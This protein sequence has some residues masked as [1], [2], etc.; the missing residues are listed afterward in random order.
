MCGIAGFLDF[1]GIDKDKSKG[2][3]KS[4][5]NTLIHRGPD[6]EGYYLDQ[7]VALGHR[8]LSIIDLESG[9][10]PMVEL[11]KAVIVF[12]G[13]IYNFK[14]V[15]CELESLGYSF[16]TNSDTEVIL[17]SYLQWGVECLNRLNGMFA[18][19]IW[20]IEKKI[21]FL[22]RDRIGKK[23]LYYTNS[24]GKI[25]FGSEIKAL[26]TT[27]TT[28]KELDYE[29]LDCFF[30]YGY[31]PSPKTIFKDIKKLEPGHYLIFSKNGL[32]KKRYWT[33]EFEPQDR[34]SIEDAAD[35][36]LDIFKDAVKIRMI[37]DVPL[38]AFLSGGIDSPLVVSMMSELSSKKVLTNSIGFD[39]DK[40]NE[41]PIA[42]EIATI[43]N[44]NHKEYVVKPEIHNVLQKILYHLDEPIADSS[45]IPTYYVC[46]IAKQSCTVSL[47]GDG[48]DE[49][50]GG[51]TFRYLPHLYE[52]K[53]KKY[54][55]TTIR[56]T[57]FSLLG[58]IYPKSPKLPNVLRLK[59]IFQNLSVSDE[60]AFFKDLIWLPLEIR[61]NLYS[62][63][64][65]RNL[66]GFTPFECIYPLYKKVKHLDPVSRAQYCDLNFYLPE[67]VLVKVDRMSMAVSLEVRAPLLDYRIIEFGAKLP[68]NLKVS[69]KKG[70]LVLR[71]VL[72]RY[73]PQE[74]INRPKQGFS[75]PEAKW[76]VT[77]LRPLIEK[78]ICKQN[79][80]IQE[81]FDVN[82]LKSLWQ[83][84]IKNEENNSVF[85]WGLMIFSLWEDRFYL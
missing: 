80:L 43:L 65:K 8:R 9:N 20:D 64:F 22:A 15:R 39:V 49:S 32:T 41:L 50:F 18:F 36:F 67:D 66:H 12:N 24:N 2:L 83:K 30:S 23:P 60:M 75:I 79:S 46:K 26:T 73:I 4:M 25:L 70:K 38:G 52:C 17:K 6:E 5:V 14:Q 71:H 69:S 82:Y 63:N 81:L 1:R 53:L 74:I 35:E 16:S 19:A 42:R 7:F 57:I 55:P 59:T 58:N 61:K 29:A 3:L 48:G 47:S 56:K 33:V 72:K 62:E 10:Q 76:L 85:F 11:N 51:Y 68:L 77:T 78:A 28:S 21:L 84:Q 37:S 31:I 44:T 34:L 13:E 40:F 54:I 27:N 45:V